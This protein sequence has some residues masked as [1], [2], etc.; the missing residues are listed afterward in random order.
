MKSSPLL[1]RI[2]AVSAAFTLLSGVLPA[3]PAVARAPQYVE[4]SFTSPVDAFSVKTGETASF[5]YSFLKTRWSDWQSYESDGDVLPGE[6][7]ELV[8]LP[9]GVTAV[10]V[11]GVASIEDI[12]VITVSKDPVKVRVTATTAVGKPSVL[13]RSDWGADESYLYDTSTE[14]SETADEAKSDN[15]APVAGQPDQRVKDCT[16]AQAKY[17]TEFKTASTVTKDSDGKSYLWP[18]QYSSKV[19]LLVVHHSALVVGGDPRPAVERVRALYKYHALSKGWGD[20]GYHYVVDEDGQIYEGRRGGKYVVGG[21]VYCNNIGTVGVVLMGNFEIEQPSQEQIKSL[22]LLLSDLAREYQI[23]LKSS[24]KFHG[25]TFDSPIVGHRDLLSTL[26]PG[27]YVSEVFGQI[28]KHVR[29]GRLSDPVIFPVTSVKPPES[30]PV[31]ESGN[32]APQAAQ[33]VSFI[34][35]TAIAINPGGKQ[36]LSFSYTAGKEGA[37]EGKRVAEVRISDPRIQL[38]VDDGNVQVPVT[39]GILLTTDLPAY[40]TASLQLIV[41]APMDPGTYSMDIAG[42]HFTIA[43]AGRRARTGDFINPFAGNPLLTVRTSSSSSSRPV[44][45][46]V[47]TDSRPSLSSASS[48]ASSASRSSSSF[49][50][51]QTSAA[52]KT[53][54]IKLSASQNPVIQFA[55]AGT[56]DGLSVKGGASLSLVSKGGVCV[57]QQNGVE[58][59]RSSALRFKSTASNTLSVNGV[60]GGTRS[61]KGVLECRIDAGSLVLINELSIDEYMAGLA[62]EP[63]SEPYQKQRAFAI[64][65][66]TYAAFYMDPSNR[67]FPGK[68]YDGSD[69][70]ASFQSYKGVGFTASNPN[71]LRAVESTKNEVLTIGGKIIKPPYFSSDDGR[72]RTPLE[73]GWKNFPF[74]DVFSSKPDPWCV[75]MGMSGHGVGMSGCGAEGQANE[76]R[77]AEQILQYYYPGTRITEL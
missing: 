59:T 39:K 49:A 23:D 64:A 12:H 70:P 35:R 31:T 29:D 34:G 7:S 32:A 51:S 5:S 17:P 57:A 20:I 16:E 73:A 41:Q 77:S 15:G 56:V 21:H 62:E 65:A 45:A 71:W 1:A 75:G 6:E 53:I 67:K 8:M 50:S 11:S 42:I 72:T 43:V 61:Y 10:R 13:S 3:L 63:D 4:R 46:R 54:R 60:G 14:T 30:A 33:G 55:D 66:R 36:R 27:Y 25:K 69:D 76:G 48:Y 2:M 68:P 22:Q 28:V 19:K 74:A 24:V 47:R 58:F 40:E 44:T 37:Y 9:Q 38:L 18:L 26:C 52:Q